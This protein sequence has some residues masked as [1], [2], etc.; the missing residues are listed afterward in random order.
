M[1]A[2]LGKLRQQADQLA[3]QFRQ[4][5][6]SDI[7]DTLSADAK[8]FG[9]REKIARQLGVPETFAVSASVQ[10]QSADIT[11]SRPLQHVALEIPSVSEEAYN[12]TRESLA[13]EGFTHVVTIKPVSM[14]ELA[15]D[16]ATRNRF[17][18]VNSSENM[19]SIVP[20]EMEVAIDPKNV[21]IKNSNN[22]STDTQIRM[23][24]DD[25]VKLKGK[26]PEEVR[27]LVSIPMPN[28]STAS[29]ADIDYQ[30]KTGKPLYPDF[31]VRTDDETVSGGVVV[32]GRRGPSRGLHVHGWGRDVGG[33]GVFA[34]R[35]VVLPRKLAVKAAE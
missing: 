32:V 29:Q 14:G 16:E 5:G 12:K 17:A 7:A 33:D 9:A 3:R 2:E 19:R 13:K 1:S 11:P 15:T 28:A 35:M 24:Q 18:F 27:D 20:T 25:E 22:K 34:A 21:R 30:D 10:P 31:W 26:L 6:Y 8:S 23:T 4:K